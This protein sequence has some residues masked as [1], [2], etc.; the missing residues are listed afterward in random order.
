MAY[1]ID[2]EKIEFIVAREREAAARAKCEKAR[3][4]HLKLAHQYQHHL[5]SLDAI[6]ASISLT[7]G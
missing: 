6:K 2:S 3:Q 7:L 4:A 1:S 5:A